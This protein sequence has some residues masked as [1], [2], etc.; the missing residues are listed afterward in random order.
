VAT[1]HDQLAK[2]DDA[3]PIVRL[4][5]NPNTDPNSLAWS[6]HGRTCPRRSG[7]PLPPWLSRWA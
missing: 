6:P 3:G 5:G 4:D 1:T 2:A 7:L